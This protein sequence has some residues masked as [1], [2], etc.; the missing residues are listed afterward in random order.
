MDLITFDVSDVPAEGAVDEAGQGIA[1]EIGKECGRG[2]AK[3][4]GD[5][6]LGFATWESTGAL[7]N[8]E[9][10]LLKPNGENQTTE[11]VNVIFEAKFITSRLFH[12]VNP[13]RLT[14]R[15]R[16]VIFGITSLGTQLSMHVVCNNQKALCE[17]QIILTAKT[18][19]P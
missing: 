1:V 19:C 7:R 2:R 8:V 3:L 11:H 17:G 16:K 13:F 10:L 5:Q 6:P 18:Q 9:I 15:G 14:Y 12:S 4:L